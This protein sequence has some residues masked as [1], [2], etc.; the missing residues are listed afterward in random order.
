MEF[1]LDNP[2]F[3]FAVL[4]IVAIDI[5]LGCDSAVVIALACRA[6]PEHQRKNGIIWGVAGAVILRVALTAVA[7]TLL[8]IPYLKILGG[9]LLLW[10]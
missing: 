1:A 3:W 9:L 8:S 7:V 5:L 4:Q 10:S 6:L 2:V